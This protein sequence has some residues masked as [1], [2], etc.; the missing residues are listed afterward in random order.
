MHLTHSLMQG[1][2]RLTLVFSQLVIASLAVSLITTL[3]AAVKWPESVTWVSAAFF[4][5][6]LVRSVS[7]WWVLRIHASHLDDIEAT[8]AA[9]RGCGNSP[10]AEVCSI[11]LP[12]WDRFAV[13]ISLGHLLQ[14]E[15][16]GREPNAAV[17]SLPPTLPPTCQIA[18]RSDGVKCCRVRVYGNEDSPC[19]R[20]RSVWW[21]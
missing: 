4:G 21:R 13:S 9:Y 8:L 18:P 19:G 3:E 17:S 11:E 5:V 20:G 1:I 2:D 6:A 15:P 7:M 16:G 12:W 10:L 14:Y